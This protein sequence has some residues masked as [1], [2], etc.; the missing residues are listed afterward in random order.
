MRAIFIAVG[1]EMLDLPLL[2][3][4]S[5]YAARKLIANGIPVDLKIIARDNL[6][7]LSWLIKKS[8]QRCQVLFI[9]GGLGPTQDDL[10]REAVA[11]ALK[12]ELIYNE[13]ILEDIKQFFK[14][15]QKQMPEVNSR[16]AFVL[17]G[18]EVIPN[19]LGTAPGQYLKIEGCQLFLL[20]G[21]PE[22]FQALFDFAFDHYLKQQ[23]K[24]NIRSRSLYLAGI[25]E[26]EV[27]QIAGSVYGQKKNPL[28]T[29]LAREGI[30]EL[31][32][33]ARAKNEDD[34]ILEEKLEEI[35]AQLRPKLQDHLFSEDEAS[36]AAVVC[37]QLADRK[38]TLSCAESC[39]GGMLAAEIV[40]VPNASAVFKGGVVAYS[41]DFKAEALSVS[42]ETLKRYGAVSANVCEEMA[43]NILQ[44]SNSSLAIAITGIAGP[45]GGTED[46]PVGLVFI[47][48]AAENKL[49]THKHNF[50]GN[51]QMIRKRSVNY[52]LFYL[53]KYLK[54]L[55]F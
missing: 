26:S 4:N 28:T 30:I 11:N 50:S 7:Q 49:A 6:D 2:D 22:E 34:Q 36:L 46:K 8:V 35:V 15:R 48:L 27:E 13:Q 37:R 44:K 19:N 9:S 1:S 21:P 17:E 33:L 39:T 3:T 29:I 43:V 23:I 14:I 41:N 32:L 24:F 16:Q 52:A 47:T 18:A 53:W 38:F 12:K 45:Q 20:P 42:E 10:T 25:G 54:N 55:D 51:R 5:I 40:S 31:H